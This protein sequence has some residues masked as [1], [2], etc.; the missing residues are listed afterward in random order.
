MQ[1]ENFFAS[2]FCIRH[3]SVNVEVFLQVAA[4]KEVCLQTCPIDLRL[5][6]IFEGFERFYL[7]DGL[8][9][10][11]LSFLFLLLFFLVLFIRIVHTNYSR[12]NTVCKQ[13]LDRL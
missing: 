10:L 8:L 5:C 13:V 2:L 12:V 9:H 6:H 1:Q 11:V 3:F 4:F 7:D